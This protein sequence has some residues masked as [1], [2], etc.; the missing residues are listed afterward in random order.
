MIDVFDVRVSDWR[1]DYIHLTNRI[2]ETES[3][4][5]GWCAIK[6][7]RKKNPKNAN[8][9][10]I[11]FELFICNDIQLGKHGKYWY[12]HISIFISW[13]FMFCCSQ[14]LQYQAEIKSI[15]P[16]DEQTRIAYRMTTQTAF[17]LWAFLTLLKV[18]W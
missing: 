8:Y 2:I 5:F 15:P 16:A 4:D 10:E 12:W 18:L 13:K 7:K 14:F 9:M 17:N 6:M 3:I 11:Q 1:F